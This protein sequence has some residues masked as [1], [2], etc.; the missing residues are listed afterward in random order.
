MYKTSLSY[1]ILPQGKICW[2]VSSA[3]ENK[4]YIPVAGPNVIF[5][6]ANPTENISKWY[7]P[8]EKWH[9]ER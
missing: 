7:L 8:S 9:F 2:N 4:E 6:G 3:H 5:I 1:H